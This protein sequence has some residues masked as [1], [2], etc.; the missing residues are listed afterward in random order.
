MTLHLEK[1][2]V[3]MKP[4]YQ[5]LFR[6]TAYAISLQAICVISISCGSDI[7]YPHPPNPPVIIEKS[8]ITDWPETGIDAE[9]NNSIQFSW[10]GNDLDIESFKVYRSES[11]LDKS[12]AFQLLD[13]IPHNGNVNSIYTY[14][15][16]NLNTKFFYHYTI[17]STNSNDDVS[18][19][20][21]TLGYRLLD[22]GWAFSMY[23]SS[24]SD[25][26]SSPTLHW[27]YYLHT[28]MEMYCVTIREYGSNEIVLREAFLPRSYTGSQEEYVMPE[29]TLSI[30]ADGNYE[31]RIELLA[32][33]QD[34]IERFGAESPW[35]QFY[36]R[37]P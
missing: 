19:S 37:Q 28:E 26:I 25:T 22:L 24:L 13:I 14:L 6:Y 1:N 10:I 23:P 17:K 3:E 18:E 9:P 5:R 16:Q 34:E 20:S 2:P 29:N 36:L 11:S 15:D 32:S 33:I 35:A 12:Y 4:H 31:W 8:K 7:E 30:I 27:N 21:D